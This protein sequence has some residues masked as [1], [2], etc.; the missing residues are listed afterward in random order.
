LVPPAGSPRERDAQR[1]QAQRRRGE[2]A[3]GAER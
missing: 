1:A 2:P 3:R